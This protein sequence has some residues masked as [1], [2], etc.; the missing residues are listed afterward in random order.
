MVINTTAYMRLCEIIINDTIILL[1]VLVQ[2]SFIMMHSS[3]FK[4]MKLERSPEGLSA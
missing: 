1:F 3:Q 4:A 2:C